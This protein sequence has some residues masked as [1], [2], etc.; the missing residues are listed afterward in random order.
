MIYNTKPYEKRIGKVPDLM[1]IG[2]FTFDIRKGA[3]RETM[4]IPKTTY[5]EARKTAFRRGF[6]VKAEEIVLL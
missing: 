1:E 4:P 3:L 5:H 2:E 6:K